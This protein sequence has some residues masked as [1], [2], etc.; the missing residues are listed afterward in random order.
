MTHP[1]RAP[2]IGSSDRSTARTACSGRT[3]THKLAVLAG[4]CH[5]VG[6]R[7]D[8]IEKTVSTRLGPG[9]S[10]DALAERCAALAALGIDHALV[11]TDG[12]WTRDSLAT[13]AAANPVLAAI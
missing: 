3:I 10:P 8:E 5:D 9:E 4:H 11:I 2:T 6:R 1:S 13:L 12:H 7:Y